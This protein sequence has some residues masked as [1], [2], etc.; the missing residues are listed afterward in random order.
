M[1]NDKIASLFLKVIPKYPR[2]R[3][4]KILNLHQAEINLGN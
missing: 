2:A 1:V 3:T 4:A